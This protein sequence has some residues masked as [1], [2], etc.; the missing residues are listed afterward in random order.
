MS[1]LVQEQGEH[2]ILYMAM[3]L[4][5]KW[6]KL[7]FSD[8]GPRLREKN[9][10]SGALDIVRSEIARAKE[11]LGLPE[12]VVVRSCYEAGRDGFWIHRA[13]A[14]LGVDNVIIDP[15]SVD[16][17]RRARRRKTDRI[18][19]R[20]LLGNLIR[21][22][23]G[24][25]VWSVVQVPS[26][27]EE[28][29]RRPQRELHRLKKERTGH[30]NRMR[31][32]LVLHGVQVK[33]SKEVL[34][35]LQSLCNGRGEALPEQLVAE[36]QR[37]HSRLALVEQQLAELE[38]AQLHAALGRGD[39]VGAKITA[40]LMLRGIG[41]VGA[42][43]LVYELF[44]WREFKNRRQLGGLLGLTPTPHQSGTLSREQGISKAG[45]P[46]LRA[47]LVEL[48]WQWLRYQPDSSLS[49]WF[50]SKFGHSSGRMRRVGIV[51]LARRLAIALWRYVEKG[52]L[53]EGATLKPAFC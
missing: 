1:Q 12:D 10:P 21:H 15:A 46:G 48:S 17:D 51:A 26:E 22:W 39:E 25:A 32:L 9:V 28:D 36:L 4:S 2:G 18:D 50:E 5:G 40:L 47:L 33:L 34:S 31:S 53:P 45:H 11:K 8:G 29:D 14:E 30:R 49:R 35:D 20:K 6:W 13:L 52:E 37:E 24:E 19:L 44:G 41:Q 43:E 42:T 16:V 27:E 23:R 3:E 7:G 38:K